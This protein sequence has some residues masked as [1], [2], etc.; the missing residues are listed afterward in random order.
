MV[1]AL[2]RGR[3][4]L[5]ILSTIAIFALVESGAQP[6]VKCAVDSPERRGNEGCSI[7][8]SRPLVASAA[9]PLYWHLDRFETLDAAQKAA[10]PD[11]VAAEAHGSVWLMTIEHQTDLHH[12]GVHVASIGPLPLPTAKRYTMRVLSSLLASGSS[13]PVHMHSGPEVWYIVAGEQCLETQHAGHRIV[14][15]EP[16]VLPSDTIHR[17]RIT[18]SKARGALG[19]VLH[20]A[21]RPGSSDLADPP[22][23]VPCRSEPA[24]KS[25]ERTREP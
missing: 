25:L 21:E 12:G 9:Q 4:T 11:G 1:A 18:A 10:G 16:F 22:T 3:M 7:L 13:T 24:N 17:G 15:G 5:S 6:P 23:L 8:A 20:D 19:L 2:E 14:A